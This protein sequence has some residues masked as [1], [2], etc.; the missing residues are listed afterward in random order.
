MRKMPN[1]TSIHILGPEI[2]LV[3]DLVKFVTAVAYHSC[4]SL[5]ES[6]LQPGARG[7]ADPCTCGVKK[8]TRTEVI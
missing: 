2:I 6:F 1:Q 3:R 7:L 5:P 8:R 4:L